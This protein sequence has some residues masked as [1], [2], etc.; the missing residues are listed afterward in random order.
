MEAILKG[1]EKVFQPSRTSGAMFV[2][3]REGTLLFV[4]G[5]FTRM[6]HMCVNP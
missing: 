6:N 1:N 3:F 4:G 2:G 5:K